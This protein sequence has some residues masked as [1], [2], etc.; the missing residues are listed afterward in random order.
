MITK[1]KLKGP[2]DE[3]IDTATN[4]VIHPSV[5]EPVI[6]WKRYSSFLKLLRVVA[7]ILQLNP[8]FNHFRGTI[9]NIVKPSEIDKSQ[10]M[11]FLLSQKEAFSSEFKLLSSEK[12]V[13][14]LSPIATLSPFIDPDGLLGSIGRI[15]RL[16]ELEFNGRHPIV[17]M[18]VAHQHN[19][20]EHQSIDYLRSVIQIEYAILKLRSLLCNIELYVKTAESE[21]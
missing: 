3:V 17:K 11:L 1:I 12:Y 14:N 7:F 4:F 9:A 16:P 2:I 18:F 21:S 13:K 10:R 8:K 15:S 19:K 6:K 20:H 5:P